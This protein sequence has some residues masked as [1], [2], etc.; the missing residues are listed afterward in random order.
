MSSQNLQGLVTP[1]IFL[2]IVGWFAYRRSQPQPVRRGRT[3]IFTVLIVFASLA[4][5]AAT[6]AV[7]TAPLFLVLAPVAL[8]L[9]LA[10]G[11]LMMRQM[12]F[13]RDRATGQIWM[14]GGLAYVGIWLATLA[15]RLGVEYTA[16]GFSAGAARA[17]SA[18]EQP[19]DPRLRSPL[20]L[21]RPVAGARVHPGA[22]RQRSHPPR[23]R[24]ALI[25][26]ACGSG[27]CDE[28]MSMPE[29]KYDPPGTRAAVDWAI[30]RRR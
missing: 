22:P 4:G 10:L 29:D 17:R 28:R 19:D 21:G 13:W 27:V 15:L 12:R 8:L 6:P 3:L 14:G 7:V 1:L 25:R 16:G 11:W 9:G 18:P 20:P 2:L 23:H 30:S 26:V 5:L 24:P